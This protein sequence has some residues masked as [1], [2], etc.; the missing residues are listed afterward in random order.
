MPR[1]PNSHP[2]GVELQVLE[3]LWQRGPSTAR[4]AH[5]VLAADRDTCFSTTLKIMQVMLKKGLLVCDDSVRPELY[6]AAESREQT[7]LF[8]VGDII[9]KAFR[10]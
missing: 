5:D 10:S 1:H 8:I 6:D 3:T 4:Q 2:T 7:Q 9:Y